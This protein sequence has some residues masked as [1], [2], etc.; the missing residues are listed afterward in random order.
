MDA[1][2]FGPAAKYL[3]KPCDISDDFYAKMEQRASTPAT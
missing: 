2:D 1:H 3:F